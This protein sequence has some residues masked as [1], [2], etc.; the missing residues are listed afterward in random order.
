MPSSRQGRIDALPADLQEL[1]RRRLSGADGP[2]GPAVGNDAE[3]GTGNGHDAAIRPAERTGP[4]PLSSAQ[5]RMWFLDQLRPGTAEYHSAVALR[6]TGPL[7]EQ[8]LESALR[9][10]VARHESLRT[11]FDESDGQAVQ[12]VHPAPDATSSVLA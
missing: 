2:S 8:A 12:I 5:Q 3:N 11:T 1:L 7:D 10:L 4:L 6:L 9:G